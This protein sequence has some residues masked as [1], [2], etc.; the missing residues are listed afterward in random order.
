MR[1]PLRMS[2]PPRPVEAPWTAA[3]AVRMPSSRL[4]CFAASSCVALNG[5]PGSMPSFFILATMSASSLAGRIGGQQRGQRARRNAWHPSR[6]PGRAARSSCRRCRG[7]RGRRRRRFR[8]L[9]RGCACAAARELVLVL[10]LDGGSHVRA[11]VHRGPREDPREVRGQP[12]FGRALGNLALEARA[13]QRE[14]ARLGAGRALAD[15]ARDVGIRIE[16]RHEVVASLGIGHGEDHRTLR[17]VEPRLRVEEVGV[18][19]ARRP[20]HRGRC[21]D[22]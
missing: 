19:I 8:A 13:H 7:R 5:L 3:T 10:Q 4:F 6:A 21:G 16:K 2:A 1:Q 22:A 14:L 9:L 12:H 18:G 15:R 17:Q 20:S 11:V